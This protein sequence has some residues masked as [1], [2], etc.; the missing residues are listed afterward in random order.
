NGDVSTAYAYD[1][2]DQ[3]VA[4]ARGAGSSCSGTTCTG[5]TW[6]NSFT[7]DSVGNILNKAG[8]A[9]TYDGAHPFRLAKFAGEISGRTYDNVGRLLSKD[10]G[11]TYRYNDAGQLIAIAVNNVNKMTATYNADGQRVKR[12]EPNGTHWYIGSGYEVYQ[13]AGS[14][15]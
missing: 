2:L 1:S 15:N 14:A 7:Y 13:Q 5:P 9:Y 11:F 6:S 8:S 4:A 3:L 10:G 12:V